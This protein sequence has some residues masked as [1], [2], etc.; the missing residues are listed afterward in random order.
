M[1]KSGSY[2]MTASWAD[3]PAW[4][5]DTT[6]FPGSSLVGNG[7]RVQGNNSNATVTVALPFSGGQAGPT[8]QARIMINNNFVVNGPQAVSVGSGTLTATA[9]GL[10]LTDGDVVTVQVTCAAGFNGWESTVTAGVGT[11]VRIT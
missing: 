9:S 3:V 5:A 1:T 2:K 7:L 4:A 8:Q 10:S 11:Y 6:G